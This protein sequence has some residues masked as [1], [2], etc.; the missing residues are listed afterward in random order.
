LSLDLGGC[1][2]TD[3]EPT[4]VFDGG[5]EPGGLLEEFGIFAELGFPEDGWFADVGFDD[6]LQ[7][8]SIMIFA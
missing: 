1:T 3:P 8:C 6:V 5:L 4:P 7:L 2:G